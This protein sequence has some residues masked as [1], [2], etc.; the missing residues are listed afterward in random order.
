VEIDSQTGLKRYNSVLQHKLPYTWPRV[1]V[2]TKEKQTTTGRL[3]QR[4]PA[5]KIQTTFLEGTTRRERRP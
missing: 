2:L 3:Q 5:G 4:K 1:Q